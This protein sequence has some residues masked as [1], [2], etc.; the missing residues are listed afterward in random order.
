MSNID[1][2]SI[3]NNRSFLSADLSSPATEVKHYQW[4]VPEISTVFRCGL[5]LTSSLWPL[6]RQETRVT[7][8]SSSDCP[9]CNMIIWNDIETWLWV[10]LSLEILVISICTKFE[11][12]PGG[13]SLHIPQRNNQT[14]TLCNLKSS[15]F[16]ESSS[17]KERKEK[18]KWRFMSFQGAVSI[19]VID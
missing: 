12:S 2:G 1:N 13:Q 9:F 7:V 8:S 10:Y 18:F 16:I 17:L 5:S 11:L 14:L 6:M 19:S 4:T 3:H 15:E